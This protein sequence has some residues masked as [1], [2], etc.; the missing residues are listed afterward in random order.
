MSEPEFH[1][2]EQKFRSAIQPL[3]SQWNQ[4]KNSIYSELRI[5]N[6]ELRVQIALK[7]GKEI[8]EF[9]EKEI[10]IFKSIASPTS[11][12]W[13]SRFKE[14]LEKLEY[15]RIYCHDQIIFKEITPDPKN[16]RIFQCRSEFL[17]DNQIQQVYFQIRLP[18]RYP[19]EPPIAD[20]FGFRH[21]IQPAG[22]H[23]NACLGKIKE[24]W[25]KDGTMGIAHF[26]LMLSY[27]TALALFTNTIN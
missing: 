15:L 7:T 10:P 24:R 3:I 8:V 23:R 13:N 17:L 12:N 1:L 16:S 9:K 21:F 26:L 5:I 11:P 19:Y 20:N 25:Q 27:Y 22:E 2:I 6:H 4:F 18:L 14:E